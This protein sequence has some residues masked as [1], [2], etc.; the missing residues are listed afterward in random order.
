[1]AEVAPF[2]AWRYNLDRL[3]SLAPLIAPPYDV[4]DEVAQ[5]ELV[6]RSPYNIVHVDLAA[7]RPDDDE[8]ENRYTRA[9]SLL[10]R[11]K[12]EQIL[13]RDPQPTLT[14]VEEAFVD[15]EGQ[16]RR[17]RGI[18][19]ALRLADFAEG[20][21]FPHEATL[22]GP[23]E[24]RFRL[25]SA[26]GMSLS[27]VFMLYESPGDEILTHWDRIDGERTPTAALGIPGVSK[28]RL[29][30]ADDPDLLG[31]AQETLAGRSVL[32]ADGH[33]RYETALRYRDEQRAQ[34]RGEGPWDFCLVYL[35]S[36]DN[37]GLAIFPTHRLLHDLPQDMVRDLPQLLTPY[38]EVEQLSSS[39]VAISAAI[40]RYLAEQQGEG[41]AF[42][43]VLADPPAAFGVRLR[44]QA[45]VE[46][47]APHRSPAGRALDV[48]VLHSVILEGILGITPE[49]I[50]AERK[51]EFAKDRNEAFRG[52]ASGEYQAGFFMNPTGLDQMLEVAG[53][54][55]RLPQKSTYFYPKLPTGLVLYGLEK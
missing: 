46:R 13:V 35:V 34:G 10:N 36:T 31:S 38:F 17:R 42:G 53:A 45:S 8:A 43:L 54:G 29:W 14:V 26:T 49:D 11:W 44:D 19:A 12:A 27:P 47:F 41:R 48:T 30:A 9:A 2:R 1:M 24:D 5:R 37:P 25:M 40:D 51:V 15:P 28:L 7:E 21:V 16:P 4:I 18:L 3:G 33:H 20:V 55:E 50:A 52:V 22:T 32:I 23:K 39:P 6:E